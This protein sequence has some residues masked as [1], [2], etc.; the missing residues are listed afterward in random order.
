LQVGEVL[1]EV[2]QR[3]GGDAVIVVE[4]VFGSADGDVDDDLL[5]SRHGVTAEDAFRDRVGQPIL[6][7]P[8]Q[9]G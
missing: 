3:V 6:S 5:V 7:Q 1:V 9:G 2:L 4:Q 8:A